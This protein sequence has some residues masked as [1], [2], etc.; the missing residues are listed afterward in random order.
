MKTFAILNQLLGEADPSTYFLDLQQSFG[1][2]YTIFCILSS[3]Q[4][5]LKSAASAE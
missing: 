4:K 5:T 1:K 3:N 2:P